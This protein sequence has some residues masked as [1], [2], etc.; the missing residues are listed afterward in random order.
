MG[1]ANAG[2]VRIEN[3]PRGANP[4][5]Q[6]RANF[7]CVLLNQ[8]RGVAAAC[9]R[10]VALHDL[11]NSLTLCGARVLRLGVANVER[12]GVQVTSKEC[13]LDVLGVVADFAKADVFFGSSSVV[14]QVCDTMSVSGAPRCRKC[15][16]S[17]SAKPHARDGDDSVCLAVE[18][19]EREGLE[20]RE[21]CR[22]VEL[23]KAHDGWLVGPRWSAWWPRP[24]CAG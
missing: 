18:P 13:R 9:E 12:H 7:M 17:F 15:A 22:G 6:N 10:L 23:A 16:E 19:E 20:S 11:N 8:N 1:A 3:R 21:V 2:V 14:G 5:T 4:K 24:D